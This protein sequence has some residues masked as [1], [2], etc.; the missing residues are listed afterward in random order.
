[1]YAYLTSVD[2][3]EYCSAK[4]GVSTM[5]KLFAHRLSPE[6]IIVNEIRPGIVKSILSKEEEKLYLEGEKI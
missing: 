1:M 5:T 6:G 4:A 2:R 3:S